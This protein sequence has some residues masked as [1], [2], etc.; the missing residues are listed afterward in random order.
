M[1]I[2]DDRRLHPKLRAIGNRTDRVNATASVFSSRMASQMKLDAGSLSATAESQLAACEGFAGGTLDGDQVPV[3]RRPERRPTMAAAG[4]AAQAYVNV[5]IETVNA[6]PGEASPAEQVTARLEDLLQQAGLPDGISRRVVPRRNFISATV[7]VALLADVA[8]MPGVSFVHAA[9]SLSLTLPVATGGSARLKPTPRAVTVGGKRQT[10]A[11]VL[12]GVVDVGGFDFAHPDFLDRHGDTRFV[13]IWDQGGDFRAPPADY[14]YGS[15]LSASRLANAVKAQRG[16]GLPAVEL[17]RQSQRSVGSHGTHVAS[18]AAGA[19]GVCPGARIAGVLVSVPE[20]QGLREQRRMNFSDSSRIVDAIEYLYSVGRELGLP[21]SI[22]ISLG[23]N[24]GAH[25]GSNG[26]CR[27]IDASLNTPGRAICVAAGNAGQEGGATPDDLGWVMGRIH[28]MGRVQSRG[29]DVELEWAVVG[30][31]IADVSENE[32]EIWYG[33][34]DRLSVAVQPPGSPD[35]FMVGPREYIENRRLDNGTVLSI[36]NELYHPTNGD[37]Y[38]AIYLSPNLN[39]GTMAPVAPGVWKVRLH[40]EEIRSGAFHAWIERD[41]PMEIGRMDQLRAFRFP[42]FFT[43]ASNVDSHSIGSLAC[44]HRV[45]GVANIDATA[46]KVHRSSSQGPTRD[47]RGKPDIAAPGTDIVAANGFGGGETWVA[48]TGTSMASPYVCGVV[49]LMLAAKPS[50][51]AAQCEGI[52]KRTARP[53]P[54]HGYEWRNDAGFGVIDPVAA[55][56][57]ARV[58]DERAE[59]RG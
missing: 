29:L 16:G 6:D 3:T 44:A 45:I 4:A 55:I 38:I 53:L 15:E 28:T 1:G 50:L 20:P 11:G 22:N 57:E 36:Y 26:P 37:N 31:G 8:A 13:A 59:R 43:A 18:I 34:Q 40:G 49:G 9:E 46:G 42:S 25:D 51:N 10:G 48:M 41:D 2:Q 54:S 12:I 23:T 56:E 30:D 33:P 14:G 47:G 58:F 39:P 19:S 5:F 17:E 52:L 35:W 21:V 7:P 24:G 27:W 32:M